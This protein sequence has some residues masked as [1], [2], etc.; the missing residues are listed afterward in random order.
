M[1]SYIYRWVRKQNCTNSTQTTGIL[2]FHIYP[3]SSLNRLTFSNNSLTLDSHLSSFLTEPFDLHIYPHSSLNRLTFTSILIPHWTVWP[4][5]TTLS[6]DHYCAEPLTIRSLS[7]CRR[8]YFA[9]C[10][11]LVC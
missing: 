8:P 7:M 9:C 10:V 2:W 1:F 11:D 6:L 3:H 4:S 5:Q